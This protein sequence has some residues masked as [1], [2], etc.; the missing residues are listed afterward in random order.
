M[1]Y[2]SISCSLEKRRKQSRHKILKVT[3]AE[4]VELKEVK[5]TYVSGPYVHMHVHMGMG[6][7]V[8]VGVRPTLIDR[9][10]E[11]VCFV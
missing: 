8:F 11:S 4:E 9:I 6:T 2:R 7:S 5:Q 1:L 10:C 3:R